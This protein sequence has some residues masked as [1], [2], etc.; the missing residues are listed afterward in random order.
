MGTAG[1]K[2]LSNEQLR[3]VEVKESAWFEACPGAGKTRAIVERFRRRSADEPRLGVALVSFTNAA[4][5]VVKQRCADSPELWEAP[6]FVGTIDTFVNRFIVAPSYKFRVGKVPAFRAN[7]DH[8]PGSNVTA[9]GERA[10]LA[11]FD[12]DEYGKAELKPGKCDDVK[13]SKALWR[14]KKQRPKCRAL[15]RAAEAAWSELSRQG[16]VT[17]GESRRRMSEYLADEETR[18]ILAEIVRYR[19]A[20]VIVDEAQDSDASDIELFIF[21]REC[22]VRLVLVGD[23]DQS[24]FEFRAR[25][26]DATDGQPEVLRFTPQLES[27]EPLNDNWRS[28]PAICAISGSLRHSGQVNRAIGP[29]L[30]CDFPIHLLQYSDE[31]NLAPTIIGVLEQYQLDPSDVVVLAHW[32][33][34]AMRAAGAGEKKKPST[35][36]LFRVATNIN[37]LQDLNRPGRERRRALG[38]LTK[39]LRNTNRETRGWT[40]EEYLD[41]IRMSRSEMDYRVL[42]LAMRAP[43]PF[44]G[45]PSD[46]LKYLD[47]C[48]ESQAAIGWSSARLVADVK[49][50]EMPTPSADAL[51]YSTVH[52]YKGRESTAV[53]LV[54]PRNSAGIE[55]WVNG[56]QSPNRRMLYVGVTR[57]QR[58]LILVTHADVS[59]A[60]VRMLGDADVNFVQ[61][62]Q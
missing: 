3:I 62:A 6:N 2:S 8:E 18:G 44:A 60:V 61:Q 29:N 4:T 48:R 16:V 52:S 19:F 5:D 11:W 14:L 50:P 28:S 15:E 25:K 33:E 38:D 31:A 22:G 46:L 17:A 1:D 51:K 54:L 32:G 35:S 7:L 40:W 59:E 49:W 26:K 9:A 43:K 34:V 53:A 20:E 45:T 58:L 42:D 57:A 30:N 41:S 55:D 47:G 12:F 24:I 37:E 36:A 39:L 21:L 13:R 27:P 56:S 23:P 10:E